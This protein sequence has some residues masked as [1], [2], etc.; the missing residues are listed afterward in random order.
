MI[1]ERAQKSLLGDDQ[2]KVVRSHVACGMVDFRKQRYSIRESQRNGRDVRATL[3]TKM[4]G[5]Q[6]LDGCKSMTS[7]ADLGG[8]EI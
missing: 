3:R 7:Q 2:R 4:H 5:G 6:G 8:R 1:Q